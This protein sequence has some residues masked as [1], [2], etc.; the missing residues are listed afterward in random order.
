MN[1][2][3]NAFAVASGK[4]TKNQLSGELVR[5]M[6]VSAFSLACGGITQAAIEIPV[7]GYLIGSFVGSL[8]G[9]FTYHIGQKAVISFCVDSGF[10]FFGL[11]AQDYTLPKELIK[12]IGI[13]TFD[14]ESF[15]IETFQPESLIFDTFEAETFEPESLDITILR[16]GVIGVSKVGYV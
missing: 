10:T 16:R 4:K 13:D 9:S 6:Y 1:V 11:V 14:Y 3:K 2:V 8:L 5:D 15:G 12:E 7:L